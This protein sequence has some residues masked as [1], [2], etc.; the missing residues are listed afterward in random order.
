[1]TEDATL[2]RVEG[3]NLVLRLIEPEDAEYVHGLRIDPRYNQYL[4]EVSG[5]TADQ[6]AWIE[7][8]KV[9]EAAGEELYYIIERLDGVRCGT[10]RLYEIEQDQFTWGSW[11]LDENKPTKA[12]LESAVLS[13]DLGFNVLC[14]TIA[15]VDARSQNDRAIGFYRRFGMT[16]VRRDEDHI[17]FKYHRAQF[18]ADYR[19][20]T[21]LTRTETKR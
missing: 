18:Y 14:K 16:E 15:L 12:A 7:R 20:A 1:M 10:V 6:R 17:Y 5:T 21:N 19:T 2:N 8:Y 9:R 3:P 13:F 4:S 11:I